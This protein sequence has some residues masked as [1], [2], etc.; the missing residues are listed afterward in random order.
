MNFTTDADAAL[1]PLLE[2]IKVE[3]YRSM[4]S[5]AN[6]LV[7]LSPERIEQ[8]LEIGKELNYTDFLIG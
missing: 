2:E 3:M 8:I 6:L 5:G 1:A 4:C 7:E